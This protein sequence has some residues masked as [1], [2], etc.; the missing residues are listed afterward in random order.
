M[1]LLQELTEEQLDKVCDSVEIFPY[2]KGDVIIKK[3]SE[4]NVFYMVKE[5]TVLV[6]D[7]GA[8][9]ADHTLTCGDYF[10]ERALITGE[11]RA[12]TITAQTAVKLMAL[13]REA[14]DA[15]LGPLKEVLDHNMNIRIL[16]SV[17][18]FE[19]LNKQEMLRISQALVIETY[20][21]GHTIVKQG[22]IGKPSACVLPSGG[23]GDMG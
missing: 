2:A 18:L 7:M 1:P 17:K 12:A 6:S 4:G 9:F 3:G 23:M 22:E 5:G 13:D 16:K 21:P 11:P 8:S 14:F 20:P 15:L 19:K 10:G